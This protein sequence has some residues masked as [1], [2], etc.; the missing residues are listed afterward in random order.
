MSNDPAS[1]SVP[2]NLPA[3]AAAPPPGRGPHTGPAA[4]FSSYQK[5]VVGVLAFLQFTI[6][7]DFMIISPLGAILLRDL[8][9]PTTKFG[10]VVS[11]YAFSASLSGLLAAGFADRFD[12]KKLLLFFYAGFT[13]GT[14]FCG[15]APTYKLLLAAR[16]VTGVFG[17]VIGSISMAIIT[18]LFPLN[19]R[20]RVMGVVQTSFA[21]SQ[22]LGLPLGLYLANHWGWHAPFLMI[23]GLTVVAGLLIFTRLQPIDG[24]LK[25]QRDGNAFAH[26][27]RTVSQRRYLK[28]FATTTLL[29]TGG[30]MLMPFGSAFT[31]NNVGISFDQLPTIYLVT[32]LC[33]LFAGP[34]IGRLS[35]RLG[36]Y[37][38]F[39]AGTALTVVMV[40]IYTHLG[41][42]ALPWVIVV[43]VLLFVGVTSRMISASALMSAVPDPAHRGS[44]MS[45]N[46][47]L[48]Q[49]AGGIGAGVAGLIVV[50]APSGALARY[51]ILGYVVVA[52]MILVVIMLRTID[53][54]VNAQRA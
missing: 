2:A 9:L 15:L 47:S 34:F 38:L 23:V 17:G 28:A 50:Q 25:L 52:A 4:S 40:L 12:R 24:H 3:P 31:I 13:A 41:H 54:M 21:A 44:F 53:R 14:L 26:L 18:D 37:L 30:F 35:D 6:I 33:T 36:K 48:Q 5:F 8:H 10:L 19:M 7:L 42:T 27:F 32:G 29:A 11:V 20:G 46:S 51:D 43:N 49:F 22:V 39:C 45:V 1:V 16:I